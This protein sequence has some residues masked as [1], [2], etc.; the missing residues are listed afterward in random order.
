M[1]FKQ[2]VFAL[3][4]AAALSP[5]RLLAEELPTPKAGLWESR[6]IS[7]NAA[8]PVTSIKQCMDGKIDLEGML[9]AA[10]GMCE[11]KWKRVASD[12]IETETAC[13]VGPV[14][15]KGKGIVIGDF[16]S[17]LRIET[18]STTSMDAM[19][20]GAPKLALPTK[21]QTMVIEARWI[22]PCEPGQKPGDFIMPDGK[23]MR[24]PTLPATPR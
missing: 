8:M 22:G 21:P 17:Q 20:A 19:P 24:M 4:M 9:K 7:S 2:F 1:A 18:T 16:N 3:G 12:R 10:G 6:M 23:V 13:K 11:L 15:T 5:D 14:S